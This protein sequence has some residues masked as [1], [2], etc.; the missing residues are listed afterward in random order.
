MEAS[1]T[2]LITK[3]MIDQDEHIKMASK[4]MT[5]SSDVRSIN[6]MKESMELRIEG[7]GLE[8]IRNPEVGIFFRKVNKLWPFWAHFLSNEE[9][10]L[11]LA[12]NLLAGVRS[13]ANTTQG[14]KTQ[15]HDGCDGASLSRAAAVMIA[16]S[17]ALRKCHNI[18][19]QEFQSVDW[20]AQSF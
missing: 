10:S 8:V 17:A 18:E 6:L 7:Y 12:L 16:A 3:E 14:P 4:L 15:F 20:L 2:I 11:V 1:R 5:L 19:Q 9:N 13:I